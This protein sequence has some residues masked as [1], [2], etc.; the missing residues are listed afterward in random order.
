VYK[1][2][3]YR[4]SIRLLSI[5]AP[6]GV[7]YDRHGSVIVDNTLSFGVFI[8]P[9]EIRDLDAEIKRLGEILGVP[10]SLL[11]RNY[12]RNYQAPF[13]PC[14]VMKN[15]SKRKA[16]LIEESR[17]DM[18]G[19]LVKE[20]PLRRYAYK[21]AFAHVVGY[22]GEIDKSELEMLKSYGYN[23]KDLIGKDGVEKVADAR[24]RGRNGGMQ[25]QVDNRG[26]QVK[27]MNFK[28]ASK[29]KDVYLT[30]DAGLQN[31]VWKM[32]KEKKGAVVFMDVSSG[33]ILTLISSPSY[34]PGGSIAGLL[35]D[36]DFSLLNR[37]IMGQYPPGSLF[38][39][40][41]ALAGLESGK[42]DS[43]TTFICNGKLK[44][45]ADRFHCWDRD[46]HGPMDLRKGIVQS[47]NVFFYNAGL[48]LGVEEISGYARQFGFGKKTGIELFGEMGGFVPSR[49]WK[50]AKRQENWYAGDTVNL[51]IG[52]GYL[53]VTPLQVA[54][55]MA[56]V[57]NGGNLVEPHVLK[58]DNT[59]D[60]NKHPLRIR[61]ENLEFVRRALRE[62]VDD[63]RGTGFRAWS[64]AVS[65]AGKTGTSQSGG[66]RRTHAWFSG[67]A[68]AE[69]PEISFVIFLEHGGSGGDVAA[70]IARKAVEYW[71]KQ[72][73]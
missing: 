15:V 58:K 56:S 11:K 6:R 36:R 60:K 37:A 46:G 32:M 28:K 62:V 71:H 51:S 25:V 54:R 47:C 16:I 42:I 64:S 29:G 1:D 8:V 41:I 18:P 61:Q 59:S 52:Q 73:K 45:G 69:K 38:K 39:I 24:L 65:I 26:R 43:S 5:K 30:I 20:F 49:A 2:L 40:V 67:F 50:K 13:A 10:E 12:K 53:L 22:V 35:N 31:F 21:E 72:R 66:G 7:I 68:P 63:D 23:V 70:L 3:S 19:V 17:L 44:V 14:E 55:M 33:E 27:I 9:Q 34:D 48:L 4:N 57:A